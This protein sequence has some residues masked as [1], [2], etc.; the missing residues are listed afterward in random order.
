M[1]IWGVQ[2]QKDFL[3]V[4][5]E[6]NNG[7]IK[8]DYLEDFFL[9]DLDDL[10]MS[11]NIVEKILKEDYVIKEEKTI[12]LICKNLERILKRFSFSEYRDSINLKE[13][14]ERQK[15]SLTDYQTELYTSEILSNKKVNI[16]EEWLY[17]IFRNNT[18]LIENDDILIKYRLSNELAS[19]NK[20]IGESAV[21]TFK[22]RVK[23]KIKHVLR[24]LLKL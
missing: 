2:E 11:D 4:I 17:E 16:H 1:R 23:R 5:L 19:L 24:K 7:N 3:N 22:Y 10:Q 13:F 21:L 8:D 15:N 9:T 14:L 20:N 12:R 6:M 18:R